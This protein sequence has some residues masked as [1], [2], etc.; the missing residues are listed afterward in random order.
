MSALPEFAL[1]PTSGQKQWFSGAAYDP[2]NPT[3]AKAVSA[4][5]IA[6]RCQTPPLPDRVLK[7]SA[8]SLM[9]DLVFPTVRRLIQR[10]IYNNY[11]HLDRHC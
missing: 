8:F 1:C 10:N 4:L 3:V 11:S 7:K 5:E 2:A 6:V 9:T